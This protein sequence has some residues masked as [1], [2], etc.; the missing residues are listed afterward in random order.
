MNTVLHI[1]VYQVT[2]GSKVTD[3]FKIFLYPD[4]S[5]TFLH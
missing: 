3:L 1:D 2:V 4:Y 5:L